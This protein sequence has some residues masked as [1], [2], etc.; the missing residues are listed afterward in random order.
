MLCATGASQEFARKRA[1]HEML[2]AFLHGH[3]LPKQKH[4]LSTSN[5]HSSP[6]SSHPPCTLMKA[7]RADGWLVT[8]AFQ[9]KLIRQQHNRSAKQAIHINQVL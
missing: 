5:K 9:V 3:A 2:A 4:S 7:A 1:E 6:T 8:N